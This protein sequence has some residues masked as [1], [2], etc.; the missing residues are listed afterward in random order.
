M[1]KGRC[2]C[3]GKVKGEVLVSKSPISFYGGV[4]PNTGK[5]IEKNHELFGISVKDKI[6]LFPYGKGSTV[7]SYVLYQM[8]KNKTAPKGIVN[9]KT[10]PIIATGCILGEIPLI[11]NVKPEVFE[12]IKTGDFIELNAN[13]GVIIVKEN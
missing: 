8:A 9:I 3:G 12:K 13:Q 11:D 5:V 6:L 4:D 7:G 2:I 10:E 1:I